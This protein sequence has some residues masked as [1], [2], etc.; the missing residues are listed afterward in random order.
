M[1]PRIIRW[2]WNNDGRWNTNYSTERIATH[3]FTT[4]GT[5]T[6]RME[7]KDTYDLTSDMALIIHVEPYNSSPTA[8]FTY[9][10]ES[11]E[12]ETEITFDASESFDME[13]DPQSLEVRW[14]F[15]NDG[16]WD[17]GY[18]G[19]KTKKYIYE[20]EGT[21][22]VRL[23]VKDSGGLTD[24]TSR[25]ITIL[26]KNQAPT[27]VIKCT[28]GYGDTQTQFTFSAASSYDV[29]DVIEDLEVRWDWDN[30]GEWDTGFDTEK[31]I[32]HR[33][34]TQ[35]TFTVTLEVRDTEGLSSTATKDVFVSDYNSSPTAKF[36]VEPEVGDTETLFT[37]D[38][39]PSFDPQEETAALQVRWDWED[40]G[41]WDTGY[42]QTKTTTH[43]YSQPGTYRF[44]MPLL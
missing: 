30:D 19:T 12:M 7:V 5:Y 24:E 29:E 3:Q 20:E 22:T 28:P 34:S 6:V 39:T 4:P 35:G 38:A 11:P 36:T 43:Q 13:D 40:D 27:A 14:D 37:F 21:Y 41:D 9:S 42:S 18:S 33:F 2:D 8:T 25:E 16:K 31:T 17:T 23:Q 26:Y 1:I 15:D 32:T 44:H 10:P